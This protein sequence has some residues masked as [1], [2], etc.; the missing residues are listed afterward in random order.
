MIQID[1]ECYFEALCDKFPCNDDSISDEEYFGALYLAIDKTCEDYANM[2]EIDWDMFDQDL[3]SNAFNEL[4][5]IM[6]KMSFK[7][8]CDVTMEF[9][10]LDGGKKSV[11]VYGVAEQPLGGEF[12][13]TE[14]LCKGIAPLVKQCDEYGDEIKELAHKM[15]WWWGGDEDVINEWLTE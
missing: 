4:S 12:N 1:K 14:E 15:S 6:G 8:K 10:A 7:F 3:Y 9:D 13:T 2:I 5:G 11:I